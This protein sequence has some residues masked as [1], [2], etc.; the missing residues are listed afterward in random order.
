[1]MTKHIELSQIIWEET[2]SKAPSKHMQIS[3]LSEK[4]LEDCNKVSLNQMKDY[5]NLKQFWLQER[6]DVQAQ[7]FSLFNAGFLM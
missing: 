3:I 7:I 6:E 4:N 5:N 1:M 2:S